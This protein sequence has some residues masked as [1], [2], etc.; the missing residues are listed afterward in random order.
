MSSRIAWVTLLDP[1]S[2]ITT[3]T[4][5]FS[6]NTKQKK[7]KLKRFR[8]LSNIEMMSLELEFCQGKCLLL[9]Q[10]NIL[11]KNMKSSEFL[12]HVFT[13]YVQVTVRNY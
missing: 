7:T 3:D 12:Q 1:V 6:K 4:H 10:V 2:K 13:Y 9:K 5:N 8:Q 11:E